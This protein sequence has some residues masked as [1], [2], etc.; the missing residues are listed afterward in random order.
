[1]YKHITVLLGTQIFFY[2]DMY[3]D[4]YCSVV[5]GGRKVVEIWVSSLEK[6]ISRI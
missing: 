3:Q 5:C 2:I 4:I 6:W 1:M